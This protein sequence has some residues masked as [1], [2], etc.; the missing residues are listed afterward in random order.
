M[1]IVNHKQ[2]SIFLILISFDQRLIL[3]CFYVA[4]KRMLRKKEIC[5]ALSAEQIVLKNVRVCYFHPLTRFTSAGNG[6]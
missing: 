5:S 1:Q 6:H 3:T 2:G 4:D